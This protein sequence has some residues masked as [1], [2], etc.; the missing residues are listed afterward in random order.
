MTSTGS[1]QERIQTYINAHPDYQGKPL[2]EFSAELV[3]AGILTVE[4]LESL[5]STST[6]SIANQNIT[7]EV[8]DKFEHTDDNEESV[9]LEG[10]TTYKETDPKTGEVRIVSV[11]YY[12]GKP[13]VKRVTT[14]S[15]DLIAV[16]SF[17]PAKLQD[18]RDVIAITSVSPKG[19]ALERTVVS[20]VDDNGNYSDEEFLSRSTLIAEDTTLP[21]GIDASAGSSYQVFVNNGNLVDVVSDKE[22]NNTVTTVYNGN[23]ISEYDAQALHR[24]AQRTINNGVTH[25]IEYDGKGNTHVVIR[26]GDGFERI[27]NYF[28]RGADE[29]RQFTQADLVALNPNEARHGLQVGET[30]LVPTEYNANDARIVRR[31]TQQQAYNAY[32]NFAS[33]QARER[34]YSST[35]EEQTLSRTYNSYDELAREML[36]KQGI[37]NPTRAQVNDRANELI[38]LNNSAPL[39]SGSKIKVVSQQSSQTDVKI[40]Q[41]RGFTPTP[42]NNAFYTKFNALNADQKQQVQNVLKSYSNITDINE[43]KAIVFETTGINLY[44]TSLTVNENRQGSMEASFYNNSM[45]LEYFI[46]NR[47]GLDLNSDTG[48]EVYNRMRQLPQSQLDNISASQFATSSRTAYGMP[49]H[50]ISVGS[51]ATYE[52]V[53]SVLANQGIDLRTRTE[54]MVEESKPEFKAKRQKDEAITLL[55]NSIGSAYEIITAQLEELKKHPIKN[56]GTIVLE[57]IKIYSIP[58]P[59]KYLINLTGIKNGT[60]DGLIKSVFD[61]KHELEDMLAK[62]YQLNSNSPN[63]ERDF[64][65]I[66]GHD[67]NPND[68]QALMDLRSN[69][70]NTQ[71]LIKPPK[72]DAEIKEFQNKS[73]ELVLKILGN[74]ETEIAQDFVNASSF[75]GNALEMAA[76]IYLTAGM[77]ELAFVK[78]VG[79]AAEALTGS[80]IIGTGVKSAAILGTYTA[81]RE[82][83]NVIDDIINANSWSGFGN[84]LIDRGEQVLS[85]SAQSA[86]FGFVAGASA[87]KL[88]K[89]SKASQNFVTNQFSKLFGKGG[90]I[91]L[92]DN[93]GAA[94]NAFIP[95]A[96]AIEVAEKALSSGTE[97]LGSELFAKVASS[98]QGLNAIG[99]TVNLILE[100]ATFAGFEITEQTAMGLAKEIFNSESELKQA[101][102]DNKLDEYLTDKIK[103]APENLWETFKEQGINLIMLKAVSFA[104]GAHS[105][106]SLKGQYETLDNSKVYN[107]EIDGQKKVVVEISNGNKIICNSTG[108]ALSFLQQSMMVESMLKAQSRTSTENTQDVEYTDI[109]AKHNAGNSYAELP[110]YTRS[111][112]PENT[113]IM[114]SQNLVI[115]T[116]TGEPVGR[117][118]L[119]APVVPEHLRTGITPEQIALL[120][121]RGI[122]LDVANEVLNDGITRVHTGKKST[123]TTATT[124]SESIEPVRRSE[125]VIDEFTEKLNQIEAPDFPEVKTHHTVEEMQEIL[126]SDIFNDPAK[127]DEVLAEWKS[128]MDSFKNVRTTEDHKRIIKMLN[129]KYG[130][131]EEKLTEMTSSSDPTIAEQGMAIFE[132]VMPLSMYYQQ[133]ASVI[134][135]IPAIREGYLEYSSKTSSSGTTHTADTP[136]PERITE[137]YLNSKYGDRFNDY[138]IEKLVE[139]SA[140]NEEKL[141][142]LLE[143]KTSYDGE[144]VYTF[145]SARAIS[146]VLELD[147]DVIERLNSLRDE[148]GN[149]LI[150]PYYFDDFAS[151]DIDTVTALA[152]LKTENGSNRFNISEIRQLADLD[153]FKVMKLA[154][155]KWK[156]D[157]SPMFNSSQ[158]QELAQSDN[159]FNIIKLTNIQTT[160]NGDTQRLNNKSLLECSE[161]GLDYIAQ[162]ESLNNIEYTTQNG[163]TNSRF[164]LDDMLTLLDSGVDINKA[165]KV[166]DIYW[167]NTGR[168]CYDV[169]EIIKIANSENY[170]NIM[171]V[172]SIQRPNK[173]GGLSRFT[174]DMMAKFSES[175]INDYIIPASKVKEVDDKGNVYQLSTNELFIG[176][177]IASTVGT[178]NPI[179][180]VKTQLK[181]KV[182]NNNQNYYYSELQ[183]PDGRTIFTGRSGRSDRAEVVEYMSNLPE[184][185]KSATAMRMLTELVENGV[186]DKHLL[187]YLPKEGE[188][189]PTLIEEVQNMYEAYLTGIPLEDVTV[190]TVESLGDITAEITAGNVFEVKG[191]KNIYIKNAD[192]TSTQLDMDKATYNRLFPAIERYASTQNSIGNCWQVTGFNGLLRDPQE[193]GNVLQCI[194]QDGNDIVIKFPNGKLEE[195][196][197][198]NGQL[199][200][201]ANG[202]YYSEGSLGLK[203]LEFAQAKEMQKDMIDRTY[204]VFDEQMRNATTEVEKEDILYRKDRFTQRLETYQDNLYIYEDGDGTGWSWGSSGFDISINQYRDG[205]RSN[206]VWDLLGYPEAETYKFD[207]CDPQEL[208][209][210]YTDPETYKTHL[211]A[212]ASDGAGEVSVAKS[213][214]LVSGHAYILAPN[215]DANNNIVDFSVVN[216]WGI[217]ETKISPD[218]VLNLGKAFY[219]AKRKNIPD[220][221]KIKTHNLTAETTSSSSSQGNSAVEL[222]VYSRSNLPENTV[223][224]PQTNLVISTVSGKPI[225]TLDPSVSTKTATPMATETRNTL[226]ENLQKVLANAKSEDIIDN[227]FNQVLSECA[228]ADQQYFIDIL[229]KNIRKYGFKYENGQKLP[230]LTPEEIHNASLNI[231]EAIAPFKQDVLKTFDE[232]AR[233]TGLG[234]GRATRRFKGEL[235]DGSTNLASL[236]SKIERQIR[237]PSQDGLIE[238]V[239]TNNGNVA[240][241]HIPDM[242]GGR[243]LPDTPEEMNNVYSAIC[244]AIKAGVFIPTEIENICGEGIDP[245]LS[246]AQMRELDDLCTS[247]GQ[248]GAV[249]GI[250][251]PGCRTIR[252]S[253]YT[254]VHVN[255]FIKAVDAKGNVQ[256]IPVEIQVRSEDVQNIL[257]IDHIPYDVINGKNIT[258]GKHPESVELLQPLVD[259]FTR[260]SQNETDL[261]NWYKYKTARTRAAKEHTPIPLPS[262]YNLPDIVSYDNIMRIDKMV[263]DIEKAYKENKE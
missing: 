90:E 73:T 247:V 162:L 25:Y 80:R 204:E 207:D 161:K 190:P 12:N 45:P 37:T 21:N 251:E 177:R 160:I 239:K 54:I 193:V 262:D 85:N 93:A 120:E 124:S 179:E 41:S 234:E 8:T 202:K 186:V 169:D 1:V 125:V 86:L 31:G 261:M 171:K 206:T 97:I 260:I 108:E 213:K 240:I 7:E 17:S 163:I 218:D 209:D 257:E 157:N 147:I 42:E 216:P 214:G 36:K 34:I 4:E 212:W 211:V 96:Q 67:Y 208:K 68:V 6:F 131:I 155:C 252:L 166:A 128:D 221:V 181:E 140:G 102:A 47:L 253:G 150:D 222:P 117:L 30:I 129:E 189:I 178:E 69:F 133:I 99:K 33:Q 100:T 245:Y 205:G 152:E 78:N 138:E 237:K 111:N 130:A 72:T 159:L 16:Y 27:T 55:K 122:S 58:K 224:M 243:F 95:S 227:Y 48:K 174:V 238:A 46:T 217:V 192:G 13:S 185:S 198:E 106:N 35:L 61:K 141:A 255:G 77:G 156:D 201:D 62:V 24:Q 84:S 26:N 59:I 14:E 28:N 134:D 233:A 10:E 188:M 172:A 79:T 183:T 44:D 229:N 139:I 60:V 223:I 136:I 246:E 203:L 241:E 226:G 57:D 249:A 94:T 89:M 200:E 76:M 114:P 127:F 168:P 53:A 149:L 199:P 231:T 103:N 154:E 38:L 43:L 5:D 167:E 164:S 182:D 11:T 250:D 22:N 65:A 244:D 184:V 109:S 254:S 236:D 126:K 9:V 153:L 3:S 248:E 196:R 116:I 74:D 194:K 145:E 113:T 170:D 52:N 23:S 107:A 40:L 180:K 121:S 165:L 29:S 228:P 263:H 83:L 235:P 51:D 39:T 142:R 137:E 259:E 19:N 20:G 146:R 56:I 75:T 101:I 105:A 92:A 64:K 66:T 2:S 82:S 118:A 104:I 176:L 15:G 215:V 148:S 50:K 144:E 191:Q 115:S 98:T 70:A 132:K 175:D 63:F 91:V 158:I 187:Q 225:G 173:D 71:Q 210:F 219:V 232:I 87:E 220:N 49:N 110:E 88:F 81:G 123:S 143:M 151:K 256:L 258:D 197:F 230:L 18:G 119:K 32:A 112:L 135:N 242:F 195:I